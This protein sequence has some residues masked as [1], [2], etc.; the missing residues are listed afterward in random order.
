M[1]LCENFESAAVGAAP[2]AAVWSVGGTPNCY[3]G[4]GK[5]TIDGTVVHS[6]HQSV[7]IDPGPNYCGHTFI[8]NSKI[9]TMGPVVYGRFWLRLA[10]VLGDQHVTVMSMR[11]A[12]TSDS[13]NDQELRLGGQ[14]GVM[15]WNRSSPDDTLPSLSP[16]GIG[17]S[18]KIPA[19]TWT[20]VEFSLDSNMGTIQTW[21]NGTTV[22]ALQLDG[23][24]TPDVDEAWLNSNPSWKPMVT[25]LKL[26]WETYGNIN[27]T[28]WIDDVVLH[29]SRIGC[30]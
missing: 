7:R 14:S 16:T 28:V 21:V 27:N 18:V 23:I 5:A 25:D 13:Q 20:C 4:S 17:L 3:D 10:Q 6:G 9:A 1:A 26:G 19:Q 2:N 30:N 8:I 22:A 11:D 15:T 24:K 29:T 12:I